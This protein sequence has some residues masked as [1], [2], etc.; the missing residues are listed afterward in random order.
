MNPFPIVLAL[1]RRTRVTSALFLLLIAISIA[2]GV[3]IIAQE[4][5]LRT[6]SAPFISPSKPIK[7]MKKQKNAAQTGGVELFA[8]YILIIAGWGEP[9]E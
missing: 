1:W 4:R 3:A 2:L 9:P 7:P 6:G 8:N 5:G